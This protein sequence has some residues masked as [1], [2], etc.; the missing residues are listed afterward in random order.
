MVSSA[1]EP[2]VSSAL[3]A[4]RRMFD[5]GF[6]TG[7]TSVVDE[8]C[9]PELVEHQFGLAGGGRQAIAQVKEAIVDVHRA[10]PDM[11]FTIEDVAEAGD[12]IW[13]RVTGR[14]TSTGPFFGPPTGSSVELTVIDIARVVDGRIVE[15]WGVPDRFALLAQTGVLDRL[16]GPQRR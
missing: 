14:G 5:E 6:S 12:R 9:S 10:F 11:A 7:G 15:H 13:V 3:T 8:V 16:A 4:I 2:E 1:T